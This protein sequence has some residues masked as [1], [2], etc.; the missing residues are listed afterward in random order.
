MRLLQRLQRIDKRVYDRVTRV[1]TPTL[2]GYTPKFV[3]TTD[4]MAP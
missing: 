2:D 4:N 3:Q 1:G